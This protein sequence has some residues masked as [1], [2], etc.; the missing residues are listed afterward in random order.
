MNN[1]MKGAAVLLC[2]TW[3]AVDAHAQSARCLQ[4]AVRNVSINTKQDDEFTRV[5]WEAGRCKGTMELNG[6]VRL[7]GDLS[8]FESISPGGKV[9]IETDDGDRK[10]ELTLTPSNDRFAYLYEVDGDRRAWD[11]EGKAWLASVMTFLVRRAGFGADERVDYLLRTGGTNAVLQ[12]VVAIDSDH[13]QRI[14]LNKLL[15]KT[16]LNGGAV[17]TVINLAG[18]ELES[19]YEL[20]QFLIAVA[21]RYEF[22]NESRAAF[23]KAVAS[24]DSDYEHRRTL[25]AVLKKGGLSTGDVTAVLSSAN[26]IGSDYEKAELLIG[27]ANRYRFDQPM[28]SAYLDAT[29]NIGSDY[30]K[31]RVFKALLKQEGLSASD[32]AQ[33][34]DGSA[35]I[36]SDYE[37]SQ[38]LKQLS[39]T[40][41][42][43]RPAVQQ[44][45]V[46]AASEIDS[47]YEVRQVLS[48]VLK[49]DR[50]TPPAVDAV[51]S[52]S[53]TIDSDHERAELLTQ[54][55]NNHE[56]SQAQRRRVMEMVADMSSEHY[57]GRVSSLLLRQISN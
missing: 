1:L 26:T 35:T 47:D 25:S 23:I 18:R 32:M 7:A 38:I 46:K 20:A 43:T 55:L 2:A 14:Y 10:R 28:R 31:G 11:N 57:R 36:R 6:R 9:T 49:R 12:E 53:E 30:E 3:A 48:A 29:R 56:L 19:D 8:G 13:T 40:L 37:R 4:D 50:L 54:L 41:D 45:Y 16:T 33:L 17:Q 24:I 52:V 51:L 27:I 44:A 5:K 39:G 42:F 34:L 21:E 22:T 15:G